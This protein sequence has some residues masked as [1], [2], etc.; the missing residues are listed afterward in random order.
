MMPREVTLY[1]GKRYGG[2]TPWIARI[3]GTHPKWR[4]NRHF[5][6]VQRSMSRSGRTGY[7][8]IQVTTPGLYECAHA[9]ADGTRREYYLVIDRGD[10][11][12][13]EPVPA[14]RIHGLAEMLDKGATV[15]ALWAA[16]EDPICPP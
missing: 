7:A 8:S 5:L 15:D 16:V 3:I 1:A 12:A 2:G 4:I 10:R 11:L 6:P 9:W 13:A 14:G